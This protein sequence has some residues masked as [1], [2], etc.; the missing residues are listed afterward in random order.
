MEEGSLSGSIINFSS[1]NNPIDISRFGGK[2]ALYS[3][4]SSREVNG[5][6]VK[7]FRFVFCRPAF[8]W[9]ALRS[10]PYQVENF[11]GYLIRINFNEYR[12]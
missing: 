2:F 8:S 4:L 9:I 1:R 5:D 11:A 10:K 12:I 7:H 6:V 3:I